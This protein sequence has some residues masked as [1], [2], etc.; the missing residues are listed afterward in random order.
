MSFKGCNLED[1]IKEICNKPDDLKKERVIKEKPVGDVSENVANENTEEI[2]KNKCEEQL[3]QIENDPD[4]L[5]EES[6]PETK[7]KTPIDYSLSNDERTVVQ[8]IL[9]DSQNRNIPVSFVNQV[10]Y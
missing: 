5:E 3:E 6:S 4:D 1:I 9:Q 10:I 8:N 7:A 2:T